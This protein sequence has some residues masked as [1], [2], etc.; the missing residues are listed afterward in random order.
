MEDQIPLPRTFI[1]DRR[2]NERVGTEAVI[3]PLRLPTPLDGL[4]PSPMAYHVT[5]HGGPYLMLPEEA[6]KYRA[7]HHDQ[8][9]VVI[10]VLKNRTGPRNP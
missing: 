1:S 3:I 7:R 2:L 4:Q 6:E 10:S 5:A 9:N 8:N